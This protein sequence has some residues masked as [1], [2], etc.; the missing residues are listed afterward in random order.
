MSRMS[1]RRLLGARIISAAVLATA[2]AAVLIPGVAGAHATARAA[3]VP[4]C[5]ASQLVDWLDTTP[6]G[7]AGTTYF[8]LQLTNFGV[9]CT[10]RG[11]PGVS[12]VS[13]SGHQL[14]RAASRVSGTAVKTVTVRR[15]GTVKAT[16]GVVD[17]GAIPRFQCQ[18]VTAVGI[19]VF[20]PNASTASVIPFPLGVC[21]AT[22]AGSLTIRPVTN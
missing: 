15:G 2:T 7:T 6:N 1:H 13:L 9:A 22:G 17:T 10:L 11:Y 8:E 5:K 18:P 21:S 19:R 16:V 12:A 3:A 4:A 20:A 14:G